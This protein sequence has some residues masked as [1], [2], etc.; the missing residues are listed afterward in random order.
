[1]VGDFVSL[2]PIY[3]NIL[4]NAVEPRLDDISRYSQIIVRHDVNRADFCP[5]VSRDRVLSKKFNANIADDDCKTSCQDPNERVDVQCDYYP[6]K[7]AWKQKGFE[8]QRRSISWS[9]LPVMHMRLTRMIVFVQWCI[10]KPF[11][12]Y[13]LQIRKQ[14]S[15][16]YQDQVRQ[17]SH[18]LLAGS[19]NFI[20]RGANAALRIGCFLLL[21][22]LNQPSPQALV[23]NR[24][25]IARASAWLN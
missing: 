16:C 24:A 4:W 18:V 6:C 3:L 23:M 17:V 15:W 11:S 12:Q 1:M 21:V 10:S 13:N 14:C 5:L 20:G 25:D 8:A 9:F 22:A 7:Y 19:S 2:T